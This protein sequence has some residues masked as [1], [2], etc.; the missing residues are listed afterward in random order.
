LKA[1]TD[2]E[3]IRVSAANRGELPAR[4]AERILAD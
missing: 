4:L 1:R 3:T 2:S